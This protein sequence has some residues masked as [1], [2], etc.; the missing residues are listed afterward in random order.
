MLV[1][2]IIMVN[3]GDC[4]FVFKVHDAKNR[5]KTIIAVND[6]SGITDYIMTD[7]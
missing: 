2:I 1:H 7:N 4:A 5:S 3:R 6:D